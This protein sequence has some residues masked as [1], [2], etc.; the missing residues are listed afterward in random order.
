MIRD[1]VGEAHRNGRGAVGLRRVLRS[2]EQGEVQTLMLG[3]SF[4]APGVKCYNCGHMDMHVTPACAICGKENT[5]LEDIGD[6]IVGHAIRTGVELVYVPD[7][8][9][10]DKI[11][12]IAALLRFRADQNT[13]EKVAS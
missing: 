11:G 9:E 13:A 6:A 5:E 4:H 3:S 7:D 2:L 1:V 10:F 12:R 8:E